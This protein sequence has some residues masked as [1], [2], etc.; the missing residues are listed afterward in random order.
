MHTR[1]LPMALSLLRPL[2]SLWMFL[3]LILVAM[4]QTACT[5][6]DPVIAEQYTND[7]VKPQS[8]VAVHSVVPAEASRGTLITITGKNFSSDPAMNRVIFPPHEYAPV[9]EAS[10]TQLLVSTPPTAKSGRIIVQSGLWS[11]TSKVSWTSVPIGWEPVSIKGIIYSTVRPGQIVRIVGRGY[12]PDISQ[13]IVY[14]GHRRA[15]IQAASPDTLTVVVPDSIQDDYVVVRSPS[16]TAISSYKYH[17]FNPDDSVNPRFGKITLSNVQ[18]G[19]QDHM[20]CYEDCIEEMYQE[21]AELLSM[22]S[23]FYPQNDTLWSTKWGEAPPLIF[24]RQTLAVKADEIVYLG[25]AQIDWCRIPYELHIPLHTS[26]AV[27]AMPERGHFKVELKGEQLAGI[28]EAPM[29]GGSG[30]E[31]SGSCLCACTRYMTSYA[32]LPET[33]LTIEFWY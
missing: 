32:F 7:Y 31:S 21:G 27:E 25:D 28:L 22:S 13:Q 29:M 23:S 24:D 19:Y 1:H 8:R 6:L 5:T 18:I 4:S 30:S 14:F 16:Y 10:E 9:L 12:S 33:T 15:A 2:L 11:D 3:L 20:Y 26:I 17:V